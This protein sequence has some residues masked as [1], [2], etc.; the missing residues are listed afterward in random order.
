MKQLEVSS[1]LDSDVFYSNSE[2]N[3]STNESLPKSSITIVPKQAQS[4]EIKSLLLDIRD[5]L[6]NIESS[7]KLLMKEKRIDERFATEVA[8][9]FSIHL[10]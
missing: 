6:R 8:C 2:P 5:R 3:D 10:F 4:P 9:N 1:F 7:L